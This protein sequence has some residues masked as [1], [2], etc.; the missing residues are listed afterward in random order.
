MEQLPYYLIKVS[1]A[2]AVFYG[3]YYWLFRTR[4][5]FVFNRIYLAG[6]F[7]AAFIIPLI[8]FST[9][10]QLSKATN[11]LTGDL[12]ADVIVSATTGI[13]LDSSIGIT[14]ILLCLY[15]CGVFF[16]L[17]ELIYG[18]IAAVGIRKS[19]T[20][21]F[22]GDMQVLVSEENNRAFTFL[23]KIIIGKNLLDNPSMEM[24]LN[25]EAVH[26]RER[27]FFDILLAEL[28]LA[29]QWFNPF[30]WLHV[31][32]IRNNLEFRADDVVIQASDKKKYQLTMLGMSLN[33][34]DSTLYTALNS[35][36]LKK[37][38]VMMNSNN[39][40][41][42][43]LLTRLAI[44]P[45]FALLIACL[46]TQKP[47]QISD[48]VSNG[49]QLTQLSTGLQENPSQPV[50]SI[51]EISKHFQKN[52]KYPLEARS[53]H[54]IGTVRIYARV[55][56][57]GSIQEVLDVK[58]KEEFLEFDEV[59]II[60]YLNEEGKKLR[61]TKSYRHESLLAEGRR[62]VEMLPKLEIPEFQGNLIQFNF[63]YDLRQAIR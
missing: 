56:P 59:V 9:T 47:A 17:V 3:T 23:D 15:G 25:H 49:E 38:I 10:S 62:V 20:E 37:R 43:S 63:K 40:N 26:S 46:S 5:Q 34:I 18:Y 22:I 6:S 29:F 7:L 55:N 30:A 32:A 27:H 33:S 45:V 16:L 14:T 31:E 28:F 52:L 60:A 41:Q 4:K 57:D 21:Q 19:C 13:E 8:T 42:F 48:N 54:L 44:I 2:T 50:N 58:P 24:V 36:N 61:K 35:S 12:D 51:E 11:F 39:K 1:I 53:A